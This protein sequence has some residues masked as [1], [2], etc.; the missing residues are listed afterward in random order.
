M[1]KIRLKFNLGLVLLKIVGIT[2]SIFGGGGSA[3][4]T[5]SV[6]VDPPVLKLPKLYL[7]Q[8]L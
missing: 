1:P 7:L 5:A 2:Y 4:A 8:H 6:K 3:A